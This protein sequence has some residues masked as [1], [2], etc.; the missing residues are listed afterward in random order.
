MTALRAGRLA[1]TTELLLLDLF[2]F[3]TVLNL[4]ELGR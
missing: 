3:V 2:F 1:M 4:L